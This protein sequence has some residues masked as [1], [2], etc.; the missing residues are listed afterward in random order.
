MTKGGC[1]EKKAVVLT[2]GGCIPEEAVATLRFRFE[3]R[4]SQAA[5]PSQISGRRNPIGRGNI[6]GE[7][8]MDPLFTMQY[9]ICPRNPDT[10]LRHSP[11]FNKKG[12]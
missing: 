6:N 8:S 9:E 1:I 3:Q 12:F 5:N 11:F 2:E 4:K 7:T 10:I